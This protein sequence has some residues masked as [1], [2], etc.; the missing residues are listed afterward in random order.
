M[1]KYINLIAL[2]LIYTAN[3]YA[4]SPN[5]LL[6]IA[7]DYG[8]DAINGYSLGDVNPTTPHLDSLKYSGLLFNNP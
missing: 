2:I 6:I 4:Q 8:V 3:T 7:D 1:I 5:I